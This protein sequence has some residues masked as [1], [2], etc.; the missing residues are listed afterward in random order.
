MGYVITV[1]DRP[2]REHLRP[3]HQDAHYQYLRDNA[4]K[5][6]LRGGFPNDRGDGFVGG[7]L[8]LDVDTREA[9]Q[10]FIANDPY[11]KAGMQGEVTIVRFKAAHC[12]GLE[13]WR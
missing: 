1:F 7:M 11:A 5:I 8:V 4:D 10:D 12:A 9:A 3:Q 6:L 13:R 2:D